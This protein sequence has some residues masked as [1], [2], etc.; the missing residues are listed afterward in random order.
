MKATSVIFF[1][2][3]A[4]TAFAAEPPMPPSPIAEFRTWLNSPAERQVALAK[5]SP[6]RR[7]EIEK[8]IADYLALP[9]MERNLKLSATEFQWYLKQLMKMSP[10]PARDSAVGNVPAP[11]QPMIMQRLE[12]WDKMPVNLKTNAL[13]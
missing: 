1:L 7:A 6:Q 12:D 4:V 5:R 10:G 9:P 8:K 13:T 2:F 3:C 11:W